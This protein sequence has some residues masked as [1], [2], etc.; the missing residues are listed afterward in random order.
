M[1]GVRICKRTDMQCSTPNMCA[2][3]GGCLA[4]TTPAR[5]HEESRAISM[6]TDDQA[7][8][9]FIRWRTG[10]GASTA[11]SLKAELGVAEYV[12]TIFA[13]VPE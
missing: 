6:L 12:S 4:P 13:G 3:F 10:Y 8:A 7:M 1:T 5:A 11:P 2:P 9:S